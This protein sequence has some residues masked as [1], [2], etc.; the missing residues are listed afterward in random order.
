MSS[1]IKTPIIFIFVLYRLTVLMSWSFVPSLMLMVLCLRLDK[2]LH[3]FLKPIHKA[4]DKVNEKLGNTV[5]NT[6]NN[7][8][9]LKFYSWD[10]HFKQEIIDKK[11]ESTA[12]QMTCEL[13]YCFFTL[14]WI[15]LPWM[16]NVTAF[17]VYLGRGFVLTLPLAMEIMG[18][19]DHVR[20]P[21]S[22]LQHL[23]QQV[24]DI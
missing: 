13:Y 15:F 8:K 23:R 20:H 11:K 1:I 10:D 14:M 18:L 19:I 4:R 16:M 21:M 12:H 7:I 9:A 24:A 5:T 22:Q 6:L 17:A 2:Y 3:K